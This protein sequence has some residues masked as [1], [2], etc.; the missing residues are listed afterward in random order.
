MPKFSLTIGDNAS[1]AATLAAVTEL[2]ATGSGRTD[3]YYIYLQSI[4]LLSTL[5]TSG[6]GAGRL[7]RVVVTIPSIPTFTPTLFGQT[8][9][10]GCIQLQAGTLGLPAGT[11]PILFAASGGTAL[12]D[13]TYT[14]YRQANTALQNQAFLLGK[15]DIN[16][17]AVTV[18]P[19]FALETQ[20]TA[21]SPNWNSVLEGV[22]GA[23]V[24]YQIEFPPGSGTV[25]LID[26]QTR[27]QSNAIFQPGNAGS[28]VIGPVL[29]YDSTI[30]API[31]V[32]IDQTEFS[33]LATPPNLLP[34][35][36][37]LQ[38]TGGATPST[39]TL[40]APNDG[41]NNGSGA[42]ISTPT[43]TPN[44]DFNLFDIRLFSAPRSSADPPATQDLNARGIRSEP[45]IQYAFLSWS[46][47]KQVAIRAFGNASSVGYVAGVGGVVAVGD[48]TTAGNAINS[49]VYGG[50]SYL[51]TVVPN[52]SV[53]NVR[54]YIQ[55]GAAAPH[56][57][58]FTNA[59]ILC[60]FDGTGGFGA[61]VSLT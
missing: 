18:N 30:P 25:V 38:V 26:T 56:T 24:Q 44:A 6:D 46:P 58:V 61:P 22:V 57:T 41:T 3:L 47:T 13:G 35:T 15:L 23:T 51:V 12:Y 34:G 20:T 40:Y 4:N 36:V 32:T 9:N 39:F 53:R 7:Y 49:Y 48:P 16:Q 10:P 50:T 59:L 11:A 60:P 43:T 27:P 55:P 17:N 8:A 31:T 14:Y 28:R 37:G 2:A 5:S 29:Y 54:F 45:L 52:G 21:T 1:I 19:T 42:V 33:S